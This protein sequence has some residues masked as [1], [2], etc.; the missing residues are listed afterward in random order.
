M[1]NLKDLMLRVNT[2]VEDY[3]D[4]SLLVKREDL[5]CREPGPQFSK[6]RG[7]FAHIEKQAQLGFTTFGALDTY[8]SQ[9]GHAVARAC[10]ILGLRCVTFYPEYAKEPGHRP[11]QARAAALGAEL[12]GL[13]A[14][15]S[16]VL[17]NQ[18][19]KQLRLNYGKNAYMMP[20]ALKLPESVE[21]TAKEVG[22]EC[23]AANIVIVPISS[24][25]IA[26]GVIKGFL[27]A[28]CRPLFILHMGYS[29]SQD[30]IRA[31]I[32]SKVPEE[33]G[34]TPIQLVDEGYEYKHKAREG[35]T[36]PFPCSTYYDL[37]AFRWW[38]SEG[39]DR[40]DPTMR[41]ALLW[42]IG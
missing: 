3:P 21:E 5:A 38:M 27:A 2:P 12:V 6:T 4:L 39:R 41:R 28:N 10:Q 16:A 19:K 40:F 9:A 35:D 31:Y 36:P 20:N 42:N 14:G 26:A 18:A 25:T 33:D 1:K 34:T 17:F 22:P 37:K 32:R 29:R 11:P 23:L 24:A 13:K 7:V 8:H 30:G 15:M